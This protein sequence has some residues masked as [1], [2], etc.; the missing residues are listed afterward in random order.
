MFGKQIF[1]GAFWLKGNGRYIIA[2][3]MIV[4]VLLGVT[5]VFIPAGD[6][7]ENTVGDRA[8]WLSLA[9]AAW[10]FY[11]PGAGVNAQ[12][13]LHGAGLG[14][15]YFT[16]W[17][18]GTYIQTIIDAHELGIL[19]KTGD[20][21]FDYRVGKIFSFLKTR[22]LASNGVPYLNYDSRDG[23]P[24]GDTPSFSIDE[25]KL[26]MAL[27]NLKCVRPDLAQDIDYIVKVRNNNAALIPDPNSF[28]RSTD[29]YCYYVACAFKDFG[30]EGWDVVPSSTIAT[31]VSQSN[32]TTYGVKLPAA[33]ICTEPLLLTMFEVNPQDAK[34]TWLL[35]QVYLASEARYTATGHYTAFSEGNTGLDNPGYVYEFVVDSDGSTWKVAPSTTP[36]AYFKVAV[37]FHAIFN[38]TYTKNMVTYIGG[39]LPAPSN[40]FQ[41]GVAED[42]RVVGTTIDRTN[43]LILSAARYAISKLPAPSPTPTPTVT[44]SPS[45]SPSLSPIPSST[46][47]PSPSLSPS[48]SPSPS[49]S[50]SSSP[51]ASPSPSPSSSSTP[52]VSPSSSSPSSSPSPT[53]SPSPSSSPLETPTSSPTPSPSLSPSPS[54]SESSSPTTNNSIPWSTET[55]VI[56]VS[57][58][59]GCSLLASLLLIRLKR[60]GS[61]KFHQ[62]M[63][64]MAMDA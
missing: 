8:Y 1:R 29:F 14:W 31:I 3:S 33:H 36:I 26:Y 4:L 17:D 11:Q 20:W 57:A 63:H 25:G 28:A 46:P 50:S 9:T 56:V 19:Q 37:S 6:G 10:Q 55:V 45:S 27:Y 16:E 52:T 22:A 64:A 23:K 48:S 35:S 42:G 7:Q 32:V 38:T 18:L 60:N 54:P 59:A 44:L 49:Y 21:G 13:G 34:F 61:T 5:Q 30:F 41:D 15:P 53:S 51:S 39:K 43:G 2:S 24:Y 40:G 58:V 62:H 12:T 47:T